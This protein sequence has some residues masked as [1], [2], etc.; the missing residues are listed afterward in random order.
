MKNLS[1][2]AAVSM[3]VAMPV[4]LAAC[5]GG[6]GGSD[7]PSKSDVAS[8]YAKMLKSMGGTTNAPLMDKIASCTADKVYDKATTKTLNAMASGDKSNQPDAKDQTLLTDASKACT[9]TA[10]KS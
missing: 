1:R 5:G 9:E 7:K 3:L 8:G 10:M 2:F 6:G 4:G